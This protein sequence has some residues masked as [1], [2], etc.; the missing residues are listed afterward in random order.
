MTAKD[1][2]QDQDAENFRRK[3][4]RHRRKLFF[5][6]KRL[7][8]M[9]SRFLMNLFFSETKKKKFRASASGKKF[10]RVLL[11]GTDGVLSEPDMENE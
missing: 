7:P 2:K 6:P 8:P 10:G 9:K 3:N 1:F 11:R 4:F 5:L